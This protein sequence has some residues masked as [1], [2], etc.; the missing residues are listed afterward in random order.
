MDKKIEPIQTRIQKSNTRLDF[1]GFPQF[2][3]PLNSPIFA[4]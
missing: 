2:V 3:K 4:H 1:M